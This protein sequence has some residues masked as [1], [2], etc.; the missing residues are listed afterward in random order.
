MTNNDYEVQILNNLYMER[1]Q[2]AN[3]HTNIYWKEINFFLTLILATI[4]IPIAL[5]KLDFNAIAFL[6]VFPIAGIFFCTAGY[7]VL[8]RE[9]KEFHKSLYAISII[10]S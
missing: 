8:V 3:Q 4:T 9:S 6:F 5:V 1:S 10:F 7:W 2:L